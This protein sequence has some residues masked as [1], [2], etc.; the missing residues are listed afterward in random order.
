MLGEHVEVIL[1]GGPSA[2]PEASTIVDCT[3]EPAA[4]PARRVPWGTR[5]DQPTCLEPPSAP[6]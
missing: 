5:A 2:G 4:H 3:G 1:D 6:T